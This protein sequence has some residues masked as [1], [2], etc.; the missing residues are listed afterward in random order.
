MSNSQ[1][2]DSE[3]ELTDLDEKILDRLSENSRKAFTKIAQELEVPDTTIHF[4]VKKLKDKGHLKNY[5]TE[6]LT[7]D[8]S[9]ALA[10]STRLNA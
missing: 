2:N 4:R 10:W 9:R 1:E 3:A 7:K 8:E 5:D 6:I